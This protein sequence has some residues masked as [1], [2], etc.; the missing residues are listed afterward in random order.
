M[1]CKWKTSE[2]VAASGP[3]EAESNARREK[4]EARRREHEDAAFKLQRHW[5]SPADEHK[6][7][8]LFASTLCKTHRK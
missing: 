8:H 6:S 7:V 1:T 3:L 4:S 2:N 5:R